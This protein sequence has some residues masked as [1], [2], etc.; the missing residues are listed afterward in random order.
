VPAKRM[1]CLLVRGL[2]LLDCDDHICMGACAPGSSV[3]AEWGVLPLP[4]GMRLIQQFC[5]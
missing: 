3:S 1:P 5:L 4:E 2:L